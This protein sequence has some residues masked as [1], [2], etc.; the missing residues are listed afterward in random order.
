MSL[1]DKNSRLATLN[2]IKYEDVKKAVDELKNATTCNSMMTPD[3]EYEL[4]GLI[5]EIFGEFKE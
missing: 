2:Y 3:S 5:K 4:H 1:A